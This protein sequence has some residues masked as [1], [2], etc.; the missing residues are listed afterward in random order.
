MTAERR[1]VV[2]P[3]QVSRRRRHGIDIQR[4]RPRR[5]EA[6][7][8]RFDAVRRGR[9]A[10]DVVPA[11]RGEPGIETR[12]RADDVEH[13]HIGGHEPG[14]PSH[15][16]Q[17]LASTGAGRARDTRAAAHP[18]AHRHGRP[19]RW[20][21]RR[22]RCGRPPAAAPGCETPSTARRRAHRPR[23][24]ARPAPPSPRTRF[25]RRR[26]RAED[27]QAR[28]RC[29]W[30]ARVTCFATRTCRH[31]RRSRP[32]LRRRPRRPLRRPRFLALLDRG[33]RPRP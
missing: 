20:R 13:P 3:Q 14:E 5:D 25:R 15:E 26:C 8:L 22:R 23:C 11:Q 32:S 33:S 24:A 2:Q 30:R 12:C 27:E 16:R 1:E 28:H 19:D 17:E 18:P 7:L 31:P 10:I 29:R 6:C 4:P 21:A 9:Q